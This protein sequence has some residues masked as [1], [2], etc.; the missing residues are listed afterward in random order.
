MGRKTTCN[1]LNISYT[2]YLSKE[3]SEKVK[4]KCNGNS[5]NSYIRKLILAD[6]TALTYP[7]PRTPPPTAKQYDSYFEKKAKEEEEYRS[8]RCPKCNSRA[9]IQDGQRGCQECQI[10]F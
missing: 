5:M 6:I 4:A 9:I 7:P 10:L 1:P 8:K 2:I 3:E